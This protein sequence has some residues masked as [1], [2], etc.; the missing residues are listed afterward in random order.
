MQIV[1]LYDYIQ[2]VNQIPI[3]YKVL[4]I[5]VETMNYSG[6][7]FYTYELVPITNI[8]AIVENLVN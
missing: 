8:L 4:W 7:C 3:T 2:R 1:A 6:D 5:K